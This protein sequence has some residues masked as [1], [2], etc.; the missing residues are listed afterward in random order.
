MKEIWRRLDT[1]N[2]GTISAEEFQKGFRDQEIKTLFLSLDLKPEECEELF[3]ILAADDGEIDPEEFFTGLGK[4]L[5]A[6]AQ[7]KDIF[8]LERKI[9]DL[10]KSVKSLQRSM[11][12]HRSR[13]EPMMWV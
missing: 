9:G 12:I 4:L 1:D 6:S 7:T 2:T 5:P 3:A 13:A 11:K 10:A 8:K